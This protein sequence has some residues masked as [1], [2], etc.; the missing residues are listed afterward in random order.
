MAM[1]AAQPIH[2]S[3]VAGS[4]KLE[5]TSLPSA[6]SK[7]AGR[8]IAN[9]VDFKLWLESQVPESEADFSQ[10]VAEGDRVQLQELVAYVQQETRNTLAISALNT[11][12]DSTTRTRLAP[13][14]SLQ[15]TVPLSTLQLCDL[16]SVLG[17]YEQTI[18]TLPIDLTA[19]PDAELQNLD[20]SN[21]NNQTPDSRTDTR[22]VVSLDAARR[23]L[24]SKLRR[25][26]NRVP[27]WASSAAV[28]VFAVGLTSTLWQR[29]SGLQRSFPETVFEDGVAGT[30]SPESDASDYNAAAPDAAA[31][32]AAT[33]E[34]ATSSPEVAAPGDEDTSS[35]DNSKPPS[36][37]QIPGQPPANVAAVPE[38]A[39]RRDAVTEE[40][41]EEPTEAEERSSVTSTPSTPPN[42]RDDAQTP[43]T[44]PSLPQRTASPTPQ[45]RRAD[46]QGANAQGADVQGADVQGA[47]VQGEVSPASPPSPSRGPFTLSSNDAPSGSN[48]G[49]SRGSET[50]RF[51]QGRVESESLPQASFPPEVATSGGVADSSAERLET[52]ERLS[53]ES[54]LEP[55]VPV[56]PERIGQVRTYFQQRWEANDDG[57]LVYRLQIADSGDV[58]SFTGLTEASVNYRDRI[59]PT[60]TPPTFAPLPQAETDGSGEGS[61]VLRVVLVADGQVRVTAF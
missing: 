13:P 6:L 12:S 35:A 24:S 49:A 61:S 21:L 45:T 18:Q 44:L 57:P 40:P 52:V 28:A 26:R 58:V 3:Y 10:L 43:E 27:L 1:P 7:W 19:A 54:A 17:Q 31:P 14:A 60:E 41:A 4:C 55:S 8:P 32:D 9:V 23:G 50:F 53:I 42:R 59:L 39:P 38:T 33:L 2:Q 15:L 16:S 48:E 25:R 46:A 37:Q 51:P 30:S 47:D 36:A 11:R 29:E 22:N 5:V 20:S 34:S 56:N